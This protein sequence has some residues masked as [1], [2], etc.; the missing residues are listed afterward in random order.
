[1]R[2]LGVL[3]EALQ[4]P[5]DLDLSP[6][7]PHLCRTKA[8]ERLRTSMLIRVEPPDAPG[9]RE[10]LP[11]L[12]AKVRADRKLS[13]AS[14]LLYSPL[15]GHGLARQ[16]G[17][18]SLAAEWPNEDGYAQNPDAYMRYRLIVTRRFE[19][20]GYCVFSIHINDTN[21]V[22]VEIHEVWL[23]TRYRRIAL[24]RSMAE[25]IASILI[26]TLEQFDERIETLSVLAVD[27][28]VLICGDVYSLAGD[29]FVKDVADALDFALRD[30][31]WFGIA[32]IE[33]ECDP[34]W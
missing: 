8:A 19:P 14:A 20:V 9:L 24:G 11:V 2:E 18:I 30:Q 28:S 25:K 22:E 5:F 4:Q 32:A 10:V 31:C 21:A 3:F 12:R 23:E 7:E 13:R 1:M 6:T 26:S 15:T 34:R 16:A 17:T 33:I 29:R 27:L